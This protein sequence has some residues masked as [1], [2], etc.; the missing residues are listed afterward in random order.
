MLEQF[1]AASG[2][3]VDEW[4][5]EIG[6]GLNFKQ[7]K[8]VRLFDEI[9]NVALSTLVIAHQDRLVRFGLDLLRV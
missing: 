6:G 5:E 3:A 9:T 2:I 1:C 4:I 8:F 7:P